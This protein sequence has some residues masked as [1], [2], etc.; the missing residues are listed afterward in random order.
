VTWRE[1]RKKP[2]RL[3]TFTESRVTARRD[4]SWLDP[5]SRKGPLSPCLICL[6]VRR[7]DIAFLWADFQPAANIPS[8]TSP[9]AIPLRSL[10]DPNKSPVLESASEKGSR[11][12]SHSSARS[13][14]SDFSIWSDTGDLA[15]QLAE[16][17]LQSHLRNS[18]DRELL[19]SRKRHAKRV[20]YPQ[21]LDDGSQSGIQEEKQKIQVPRPPPRRVSR[22]ERILA[23]IMSP[24][25]RQNAQI[26][27]L[28][29]KPLL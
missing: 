4:R 27:G 29:G 21:D 9:R 10:P 26:Q 20:H 13:V 8:P 14:E 11:R 15:E 6:I 18:L 3:L 23:A 17:P 25:N 12:S 2:N 16:D 19:G 24:G 1:P 22:V 7:I 28:V 5:Q